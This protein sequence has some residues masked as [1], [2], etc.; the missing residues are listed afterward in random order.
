M[1]LAY[2]ESLV[3]RLDDE[4]DE[5]EFLAVVTR[6]ELRQLVDQVATMYQ[7]WDKMQLELARLNKM[8]ISQ[9]ARLVDLEGRMALAERGTVSSVAPRALSAV[10][11]AGQEVTERRTN[12][13]VPIARATELI[14]K[15]RIAD[16]MVARYQWWSKKARSLGVTAGQVTRGFMKELVKYAAAGSIGW[17]I[18]HYWPWR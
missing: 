1:S 16:E 17:A 12:M 7:G 9:T 11:N 3:E 4:V 5:K 14:E 18:H 10:E 8:G 6:E 13:R 2:A 15:E